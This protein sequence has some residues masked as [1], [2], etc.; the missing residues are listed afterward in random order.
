[1]IIRRI[2]IDAF[3]P[4]RDFDCELYSGMNIIRG[5]NESGKT[6]LAMFIKFIFYGLSGRGSDD[7]PSERRKYVNWDTNTA[8]GYVIAEADGK[9]YRIERRIS[10]TLRGTS[11]KEAASESLT[12]TDTETGGRVP[13]LEECPG[14]VLFG[15]PE[16]VFMNTVFSGQA[17]RG[18]IDGADTAAAVENMLFSADET[19]NVKKAAERLDKFRR[20]LLHKNGAGGE[21]HSLRE[22]IASLKGELDT[23][24]LQAS[25]LI[26][27]ESSFAANKKN[28]EEVATAIEWQEKALF[29]YD[30]LCLNRSGED[31]EKADEEK[32]KA[33]G[34]LRRLLS[35]CCD[36]SRLA[37]GRKL[38]ASIE[39]ERATSAEFSQRISE[40]EIGVAALY[41]PDSPLDPEGELNLFRSKAKTAGRFLTGAV[42]FTILAVLCGGASAALYALKSQIFMI[43]LAVTAVFAVL[44]GVLFIM[45]GKCFA[46]MREIC[47]LFDVQSEEELEREVD[48]ELSRRNEAEQLSRKAETLKLSLEQSAE[49]LE[50]LETEAK[51][52]SASFEDCCMMEQRPSAD[53]DALDRLRC[54]IAFAERRQVAAEGARAAYESAAAVSAAKWERIPRDKLASAR[55]YLRTAEM[56]ENFPVTEEDAETIRR[57]L[58]FNKAKFDACRKKN[59]AIEVELASKRAVAK[60]PAEIWDEYNAA[61]EKLKLL[62]QNYDAAILAADTLAEAGENIR[63]GIIPRIIRLASKY[64]AEATDGRYES[65]GS[66]STFRLSAVIDGHTRDSGFLSSGTEDLSYVCLR[67]ALAAELFGETMPPLIFDECFAFMDPDRTS[68]A[69][70][71][72][73]RTNNQILLFTCRPE[74]GIV[75]TM[76]LTRD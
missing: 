39:A 72:M 66:G 25:E 69:I 31:A 30:A 63:R 75:P 62:Q 42:I 58:G 8:D 71:I 38:C 2:H 54:A 23:A 48:Y 35:L 43:T 74:S 24:S 12:V 50:T 51:A 45:R 37:E 53:T 56:E 41:N 67:L 64:F 40:F 28:E 10:V 16:K 57:E 20:T 3:G 59:H 22:K 15:V 47:S 14:E 21:I 4:L 19:V 27:L 44:A 29:H 9:E 18:K 11:G 33:E 7:A 17:G 60:S 46:K 5:D 32:A 68:A 55:E 52:I 26:E 13:A 1:M 76:R 49:R 73:A 36:H 34:E 65:L 70:D 6:S 61:S